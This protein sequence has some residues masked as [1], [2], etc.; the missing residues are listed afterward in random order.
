MSK[1]IETEDT[2]MKEI[3]IAMRKLGGSV[4]RKE[5]KREIRDNSDVISEE[6]VDE[7]KV[8]KKSKQPY[9][10]LSI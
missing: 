2:I 1:M 10:R 3:L 5:I 7:I 9:H 8:S 4:T 6:M